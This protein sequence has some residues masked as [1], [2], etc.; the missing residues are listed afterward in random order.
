VQTLTVVLNPQGGTF[1]GGGC[2][3][4][5]IRAT[6]E[7]TLAGWCQ[8]RNMKPSDQAANT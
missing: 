8:G 1:Y 3:L 7:N 4:G 6:H 5:I 2:S